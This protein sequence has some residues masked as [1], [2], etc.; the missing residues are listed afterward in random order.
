[1][2]FLKKLYLHGSHFL[3]DEDGS[4]AVE[5]AVLFP[6]I[7][8]LVGFIIDRFIQYEGIDALSQAANE[9]IR[10]AIVAENEDEAVQRIKETLTDRLDSLDMGWCTG[11]DNDSC[12]EWGADDATVV[13]DQTAFETNQSAKL[14]VTTDKGWCNGSYLTLGVRAHKS[15][16]FP[17]FETFRVALANG[18]PVFHQH[19][20]IIKARVETN[21]KCS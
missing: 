5:L 3:K 9:A 17:S 4:E 8:M 10:T 2:A 7:L 11:T 14:F 16:V 12:K 21:T 15:S 13:S 19:T 1:M 20:Y 18:G 6:V